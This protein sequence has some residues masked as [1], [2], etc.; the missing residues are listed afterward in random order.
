[1]V[2]KGQEK[3]N[4]ITRDLYKW[5]NKQDISDMIFL[6]LN[7]LVQQ[8]LEATYSDIRLTKDPLNIGKNIKQ[9]KALG[10]E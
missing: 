8:A 4:E 9:R 1:M 7:A 2:L 5:N 3:I 10:L 6:D